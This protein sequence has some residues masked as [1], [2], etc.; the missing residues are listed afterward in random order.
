MDYDWWT[1]YCDEYMIIGH[2]TEYCGL[3]IKAPPPKVVYKTQ[4]E[5][6]GTNS[7]AS[8]TI[9]IRQPETIIPLEKPSDSKAILRDKFLSTDTRQKQGEMA[10][11]T[12]GGDNLHG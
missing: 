12:P 7:V 8:K 5:E 9:V 6:T 10:A 3:I 4:G 1:K 11:E 2:E